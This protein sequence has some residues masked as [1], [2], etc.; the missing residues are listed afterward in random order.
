MDIFRVWKGILCI[1]GMN[2]YIEDEYFQIEV[3]SIDDNGN[4]SV[5]VS[6]E[7]QP[8]GLTDTKPSELENYIL[9]GSFVNGKLRLSN[10]SV[11]IEADLDRDN[12]IIKGVYFKNNTPDLKATIELNKE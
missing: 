7:K 4:L 12:G 6:E 10:D 8:K 1:D 3:L 5:E 9:K 2:K 11:T